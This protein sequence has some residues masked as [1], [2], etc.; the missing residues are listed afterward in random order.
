MICPIRRNWTV[1]D[2]LALLALLGVVV[3]SFRA[4]LGDMV[5]LALKDD[6]QSHILLAPL[7][8]AWLVWLRRSRLSLLKVSPHLAGPACVVGGAILSWWGFQ[9]DTYVAWH[10]GALL[11]VLGMILSITGPALIRQFAPAVAAMAFMIPIPGTIRQALAIP[12]QSMA[13]N[14][15]HSCLDIFGVQAARMGNVLII[16]GEQ[17]AVAEACNG[18]RLVFALALVVFAFAFS[19]PLRNSVRFALILFSPLV[20]LGANVIRLVPTSLLYGVT[21]PERAEMFHDISGWL[22]LPLA[23]VVLSGLLRLFRWL[24]FP[25]MSYR[26]AYQ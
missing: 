12:L 14:V 25:V 15:T 22:M 11:A 20:A 10:S 8:A 7:V 1:V 21:S 9:S 24:E 18:M 16:N 4:P 5:T 17:V 13:T 23:L 3:W 2:A 19:T 6:E 26:L